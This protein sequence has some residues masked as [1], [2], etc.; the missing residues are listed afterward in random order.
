[1]SLLYILKTLYLNQLLKE[2]SSTA[3][4]V[5]VFSNSEKIYTQNIQTGKDT[6][7]TKKQ[8]TV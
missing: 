5:V 1:M 3:M 7:K 2:I 6:M 8:E 4:S